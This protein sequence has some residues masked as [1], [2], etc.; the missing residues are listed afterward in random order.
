LYSMPIQLWPRRTIDVIIEFLDV[1]TV[2]A[3]RV[4]QSEQAFI[5][6]WVALVT[7]GKT[8]AQIKLVVADPRDPV[9][10]LAGGAAACIGK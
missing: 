1:F 5:Q 3:L 7:Q 4:C 10:A 2:I 8:E 9:P 6:D